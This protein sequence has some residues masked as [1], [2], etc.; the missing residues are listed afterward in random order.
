MLCLQGCGECGFPQLGMPV[1]ASISRRLEDIVP[2]N[3]GVQ[4]TESNKKGVLLKLM[5]TFIFRP[6]YK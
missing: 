3:T 1:Y 2:V 4:T 6:L 5:Q